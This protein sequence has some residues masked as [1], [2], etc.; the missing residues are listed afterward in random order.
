MTL[1]AY[2][3]IHP[4]DN[5]SAPRDEVINSAVAA[6]T[7]YSGGA[8]KQRNPLVNQESLDFGET[9][10][11]VVMK[12]VTSTPLHILETYGALADFTNW[13]LLGVRKSSVT[14]LQGLV[15]IEKRLFCIDESTAPGTFSYFD[16]GTATTIFPSLVPLYQFAATTGRK[17]PAFNGRDFINAAW[18]SG[19]APFGEDVYPFRPDSTL[20]EYSSIYT[21][22]VSA[23]LGGSIIYGITWDGRNW[24]VLFNRTGTWFGAPYHYSLAFVRP[25]STG[26]AYTYDRDVGSWGGPGTFQYAFDIDFDWVGRNFL[27]FYI[28]D[29]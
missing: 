27:V 3:A 19:I 1:M 10:R 12:Y 6:G 25:Y 26:A 28:T 17:A 15:W 13:T 5:L 16:E 8:L 23:P 11:T 21:S 14:P 2:V 4:V 29:V 20:A 24:V 9:A 18:T 22:P 7:V